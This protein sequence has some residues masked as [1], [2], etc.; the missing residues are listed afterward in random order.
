[1]TVSNF[2]MLSKGAASLDGNV[3]GN[4]A[5]DFTYILADEE[6]MNFHAFADEGENWI[7]HRDDGKCLNC[8]PE[9]VQRLNSKNL[10]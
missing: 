1:M 7:K 5:A 2:N 9:M 8:D 10:A 6:N 4:F 3:K